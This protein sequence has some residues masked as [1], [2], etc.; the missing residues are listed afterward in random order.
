M[1]GE[2]GLSRVYT[3]PAYLRP[4]EETGREG[5]D[6]GMD[7]NACRGEEKRYFTAAEQ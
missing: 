7:G 1:G 2:G 3:A 6:R 4:R 5:V